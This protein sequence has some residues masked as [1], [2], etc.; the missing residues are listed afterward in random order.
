MKIIHIIILCLIVFFSYANTLQND[1]FG[2]DEKLITYNTFYTSWSN[3]PRLFQKGTPTTNR[4][5]YSFA[6]EV[7]DRGPINASFRVLDKITFFFDYQLWGKRPFGYHLENVIIHIFN[8]VVLYLIL[9][10]IFSSN[11]SFFAAFLFGIHPVMS[12]PVATVCYRGDLLATFFVLLSFYGWLRFSCDF[13]IRKYYWASL[14]FFFL[15][16]LTKESTAPLPVFILFYAWIYNKEKFVLKYQLGFWILLSFYFYIYFFVYSYSVLIVPR[17]N[18]LEQAC[19]VI[20][21]LFEYIKSFCFPLLVYP[22]PPNYSPI[23]GKIISFEVFINIIIIFSMAIAGLV[24]ARRNKLLLFSIGWFVLFYLPISNFIPLLNIMAFRYFYL[25]SIGLC[26]LVSYLIWGDNK[27]ISFSLFF[28]IGGVFL[29][30]IIHTVYINHLMKNIFVTSKSWIQNYPDNQHGYAY[31]GQEYFSMHLYDKAQDV[32]EE[33]LKHGMK[34]P[35]AKTS[36]AY[37]YIMKGNIERAKRIFQDIIVD[38]PWHIEAPRLLDQIH[39]MEAKKE[40]IIILYQK[41]LSF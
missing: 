32:F 13:R 40:Q 21:I 16:L 15:A 9:L 36:L 37:C 5:E 41:P 27:K 24:L 33:G 3:V 39:S 25:P 34:D 35:F 10:R 1:F 2:D 23:H 38:T 12:E 7:V 26:I 30:M 4:E 29:S 28:I 18:F 11:V 20:R 14:I 22:L 31:L 6:Y 8:V 17:F 19:V